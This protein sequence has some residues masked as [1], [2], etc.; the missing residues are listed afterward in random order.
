M[1]S[2]PHTFK[3]GPVVLTLPAGHVED[4]Q[5]VLTSPGRRLTVA[6]Y[7]DEAETPADI[8][9]QRHELTES[10][11]GDRAKVVRRTSVEVGG[12]P[13]FVVMYDAAEGPGRRMESCF[14][15]LKLGHNRFADVSY[16][17]AAA[18]A[19][20]DKMIASIR[21]ADGRVAS[22]DPADAA[23][24]DFFEFRMWVRPGLS[25]V[26]PYTFSHA[27]DDMAWEADAARLGE[28]RL[29]WVVERIPLPPGERA[30]AEAF[31]GEKALGELVEGA[32]LAEAGSEPGRWVWAAV[33]IDGKA[34]LRLRGRGPA[35]SGERLRAIASEVLR[36]A[37]FTGESP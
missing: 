19:D 21:M 4:T 18:A 2:A 26:S 10:V 34:A 5:F 17:A 7:E 15:V 22:A 28:P 30:P 20:F 37:T 12:R 35:G 16:S 6:R 3:A 14:L 36:L 11:V 24:V 32:N 8:A 1:K 27:E 31:R 13:G 29:A 25:R 33:T 23:V 9:A